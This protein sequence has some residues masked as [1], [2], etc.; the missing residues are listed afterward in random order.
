VTLDR[1]AEVEVG[2]IA[3]GRVTVVEAASSVRG[4]VIPGTV[5]QSFRCYEGTPAHERDEN[6]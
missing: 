1:V 2:G 4:V 5:T 3:M 6:G